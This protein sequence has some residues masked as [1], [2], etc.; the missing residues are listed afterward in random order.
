MKW[1]KMR[2][3]EAEI[4]E[5]KGNNLG[6]WTLRAELA[7]SDTF[8]CGW[9][10]DPIVVTAQESQGEAISGREAG[11]DS[12]RTEKASLTELKD[13]TDVQVGHLSQGTGQVAL[14]P[15]R[16]ES[17]GRLEL[18]SHNKLENCHFNVAESQQQAHW[19]RQ[20]TDRFLS[21]LRI[22]MTSLHSERSPTVCP[23][24]KGAISGST[25]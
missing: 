5:E 23:T 10:M 9:H 8:P 13:D 1:Q 16:G 17:F 15:A 18:T 3:T 21:D 19:R 2:V 11:S 20:R 4:A 25:S 7:E 22:F 14:A 24:W 12:R 6:T